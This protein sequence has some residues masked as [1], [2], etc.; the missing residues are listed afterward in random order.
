[1]ANL[2]SH[3]V[4]FLPKVPMNIRMI[5]CMTILSRFDDLT[6][7]IRKYFKISLASNITFWNKY[8]LPKQNHIHC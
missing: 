8:F 2:R 3:L 1:M 5:I 7:V 4:D 6:N